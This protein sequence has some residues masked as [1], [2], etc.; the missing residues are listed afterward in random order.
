MRETLVFVRDM[1]DYH[2]FYIVAGVAVVVAA[3]VA[4]MPSVN[5]VVPIG[6][7]VV[8]VVAGITGRHQQLEGDGD[9]FD[10]SCYRQ[11][12]PEDPDID[13]RYHSH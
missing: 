8:T 2:W 10:P 3:I 11:Y 13:P 7:I 9:G 12:D 4:F 1:R 5:G 6:L